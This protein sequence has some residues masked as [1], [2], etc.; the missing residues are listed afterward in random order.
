MSFTVTN[1][2]RMQIAKTSQLLCEVKDKLSNTV[3]KWP[4][5]WLISSRNPFW[6]PLLIGLHELYGIY[7]GI[8]R[9]TNLQTLFTSPNYLCAFITIIKLNYF[10]GTTNVGKLNLH[11]LHLSFPRAPKILCLNHRNQTSPMTLNPF[12]R[13]ARSFPCQLPS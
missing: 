3:I 10:Q 9:Q 7:I 1:H 5:N 11:K 8:V 2:L 6:C 4:A 12:V 13:V